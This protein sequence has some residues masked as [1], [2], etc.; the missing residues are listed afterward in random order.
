MKEDSMIIAD[1]YSNIDRYSS[2]SYIENFN[3]YLN[4]SKF[5]LIYLYLIKI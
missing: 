1:I 5:M 4:M 3:F 2:T